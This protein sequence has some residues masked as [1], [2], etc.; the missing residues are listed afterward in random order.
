MNKTQLQRSKRHTTRMPERAGSQLQVLGRAVGRPRLDTVAMSKASVREVRTRNKRSRRKV[1]VYL[2]GVQ[3][4]QV[5]ESSLGAQWLRWWPEPTPATSVI[6]SKAFSEY[7][8]R[9]NATQSRKLLT[10][11]SPSR[12]FAAL[13]KAF[14]GN[15]FEQNP[16][17][18][19]PNPG[20]ASTPLAIF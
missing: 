13:A 3:H 12:A 5:T 18:C 19:G 10:Y 2:E 9:C 14:A 15:E 4:S 6:N 20:W 1:T 8:A 11:F 7:S 17:G 16:R